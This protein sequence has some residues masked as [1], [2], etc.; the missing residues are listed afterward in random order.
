[1]DAHKSPPRAGEKLKELRGRLGL[2][3]RNVE[4]KSLY[5]AEERH[6]R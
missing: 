3:T 5:I 2:T 1:M 4:E 6:N